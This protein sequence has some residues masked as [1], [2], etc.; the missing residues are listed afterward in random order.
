MNA[1]VVKDAA[2]RFAGVRPEADR[3]GLPAVVEG[4]PTAVGEAKTAA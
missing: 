3:V 2:R 4:R 1:A